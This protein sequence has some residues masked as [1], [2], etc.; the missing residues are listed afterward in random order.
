[1][2]I[3]PWPGKIGRGPIWHCQCPSFG[4]A[5]I[6]LMQCYQYIHWWHWCFDI[7]VLWHW[8]GIGN[9]RTTYFAFGSD[10]F[11]CRAHLQIASHTIYNAHT[12]VFV[13]LRTQGAHMACSA[14]HGPPVIKYLMQELRPD[15]NLGITKCRPHFCKKTSI[16][17]LMYTERSRGFIQI[18]QP[19]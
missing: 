11:A 3:L 4:I 14:L 7:G 6:S 15:T 19:I 2:I 5:P 12:L 17:W 16:N 10:V 9:V 18:R 8:C 13:A 1:M